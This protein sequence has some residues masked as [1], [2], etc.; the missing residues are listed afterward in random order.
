MQAND[1]VLLFAALADAEGD[2]EKAAELILQMGTGR[3]PITIKYGE[4]LAERLGVEELYT[5]QFD[6]ERTGDYLG[7]DRAMAAVRAEA[8]RRGWIDA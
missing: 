3:S 8:A 1:T 7:A 2:Q 5:S 6:T 4:E